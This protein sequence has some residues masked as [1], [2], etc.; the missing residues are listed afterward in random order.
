MPTDFPEPTTDVTLA[1]EI[2]DGLPGSLVDRV[3]SSSDPGRA[4]DHT[5]FVD[6]VEQAILVDRTRAPRRS[7]H[8]P[9]R[10]SAAANRGDLTGFTTDATAI[11]VQRGI[12]YLAMEYLEGETL[13]AH[14]DGGSLFSL[15][16][17]LEIGAQTAAIM[18]AAHACGVAHGGLSADRIHI[19]PDAGEPSG[20][21]VKVLDFGAHATEPASADDALA[22]IHG[23]GCLLYR[24]LAGRP[25]THGE[26]QALETQ[27]PPPP[28]AHRADIPLPLDS[29]VHRMVA[30]RPHDRPGSMAE[31]EHQ[32]R[33]LLVGHQLVNA[34]TPSP[35]AS[36]AWSWRSLRGWWSS[37]RPV[38]QARWRE[39]A[40][41]VRQ[42]S[43]R[44]PRWSVACRGRAGHG[45]R[46]TG[47]AGLLSD[48]QAAIPYRAC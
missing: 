7:R 20:L 12:G 30:Y 25:P 45:R 29:L 1:T 38:L 37:T 41:R 4:E 46:G 28:R 35:A 39:A 40:L 21:R 2:S 36:L 44:H 3:R 48:R 16:H 23:L 10:P 15:D 34:A 8:A 27:D 31:I 33:T 13:G 22:D 6:P 5:A 18:A 26:A 24:L 9:V 32:L 42:L 47:P 17:V 19:C 43:I 14:L 11:D